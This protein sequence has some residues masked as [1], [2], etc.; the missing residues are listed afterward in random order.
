MSEST[1]ALP[2]EEGLSFPLTRESICL[3]APGSSFTM[4][5][6]CAS[7]CCSVSISELCSFNR[8]FSSA[9]ASLFF[10]GMVK[11]IRMRALATDITSL[12]LGRTSRNCCLADF[13]RSGMKRVF[14]SFSARSTKAW[15]NGR[16]VLLSTH[17]STTIVATS[18]S[19]ESNWSARSPSLT[20]RS[21][22]TMPNS[23][24]VSTQHCCVHLL[25]S[26][27]VEVLSLTCSSPLARISLHM[28]S[29]SSVLKT[30]CRTLSLATTPLETLSKTVMVCRTSSRSLSAPCLQSSTLFL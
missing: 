5:E 21:V 10:P 7:S 12:S 26:L 18:L 23:P 11:R 24:P 17:F 3:K 15:G 14:G 29:W 22:T 4:A 2:G 25:H 20:C 9:T 28:T 19:L 13:R 1:L 16:P 8:R 30:F 6:Y 27:R